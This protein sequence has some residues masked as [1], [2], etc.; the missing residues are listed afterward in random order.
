[1]DPPTLGSQTET[2]SDYSLIHFSNR[3]RCLPTAYENLQ[4]LVNNRPCV[5]TAKIC[6]SNRPGCKN[7]ARNF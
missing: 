3:G 1:M 7:L 4:H 2:I 5:A 6:G